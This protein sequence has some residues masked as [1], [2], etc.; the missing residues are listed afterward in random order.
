MYGKINTCNDSSKYPYRSLF[1]LFDEF[2]KY[3]SWQFFFV[4][5]CLSFFFDQMQQF[6]VLSV[7]PPC[8]TGWKLFAVQWNSC[9]ASCSSCFT[10]MATE[11][12][13]QL[14]LMSR[15]LVFPGTL[16]WQ[17]IRHPS[18]TV[19]AQPG[20][21]CHFSSI[22]WGVSTWNGLQLYM[23][24]FLAIIFNPRATRQYSSPGKCAIDGPL[25]W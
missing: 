14:A 25:S 12:R 1:K 20:T 2:L 22:E 23:R 21:T 10:S 7:I 4:F 11:G 18:V 19:D 3:C 8:P 17:R 5:I 13:Y 9:E 16:A 24:Q 6:I 15:L